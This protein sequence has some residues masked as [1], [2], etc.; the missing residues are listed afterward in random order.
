MLTCCV[1]L[2]IDGNKMFMSNFE[3]DNVNVNAFNWQSEL[4]RRTCS[5]LS[6]SGLTAA[7]LDPI[8]KGLTDADL[9]FMPGSCVK[10]GSKLFNRSYAD[11]IFTVRSFLQ[12]I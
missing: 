5:F 4:L 10:D 12:S 6:H 1:Q 7:V 9:Y 3:D 2:Y 11:G 8:K